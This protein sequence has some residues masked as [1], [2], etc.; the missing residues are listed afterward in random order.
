MAERVI[1]REYTVPADEAPEATYPYYC[2]PFRSQ[3]YMT[4]HVGIDHAKEWSDAE[5]EPLKR[6]DEE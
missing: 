4:T 3:R 1:K 5:R 6:D 2:R